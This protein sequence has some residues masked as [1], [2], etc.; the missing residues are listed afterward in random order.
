MSYAD[1]VTM[2]LRNRRDRRFSIVNFCVENE[3][4]IVTRI[5]SIL[6]LSRTASVEKSAFSRRSIARTSSFERLLTSESR[7]VLCS[8]ARSST[9]P[10]TPHS[11]TTPVSPDRYSIKQ[12]GYIYKIVFLNTIQTN[13]LT[14]SINKATSKLPGLSLH[15]FPNI[16]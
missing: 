14:H 2:S 11:F 9:I 1:V 4:S 3:C 7:V 13:V 8:A 15:K 5:R 12:N 10:T 16:F 6:S